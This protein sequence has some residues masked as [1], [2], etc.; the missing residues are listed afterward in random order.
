MFF[1]SARKF[2]VHFL[3]LVTTILCLLNSAAAQIGG[4]DPDPGDAGTGKN[5]I[6]GSVYY[7]SGQK[8]DKRIRVRL[9]TF[10]RGDMTTLTD[11]NGAFSFQRLAAGTYTVMIDGEKDY[12]IV[13]ERVDLMPPQTRGGSS[14]GQTITLHIQ[15]KLK[16]ANASKPSVVNSDSA[17]APPEALE[18]YRKAL[19]LA[20]SGDTKAAIEQL[21]RAIAAYPRFMLLFNELGV[22]YL[23]LGDSEKANKALE[24][25]LKLAP[26]AFTPLLNHG[27]VLVSLNRYKE[28]ESELRAAI[29]Q[30]PESAFAHYF[31][32]RTLARLRRFNEAEGYLTRA[33]QLGGDDVNEA[34]RYL[35]AIYNDRG[36]DRRAISELET[37]LRLVPSAKDA[38]QIREIIQQLKE[39]SRAA[40]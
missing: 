22:Q 5:A 39:S 12:E 36:D 1:Q 10:V 8:V 24:S 16:S 26:T 38:Q 4:I 30:N 40:K 20:Q 21:Q 18:L 14:L 11:D 13:N 31:L 2:A 34:H 6:V 32:G 15:L 19:E 7:P 23:R 28:A 29:K 25:A 9:R 35:G 33:I 3:L 27:I 37:Y 17:N